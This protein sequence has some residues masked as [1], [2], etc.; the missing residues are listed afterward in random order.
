MKNNRTIAAQNGQNLQWRFLIKITFVLLT[1][2]L[3]SPIFC[4]PMNIEDVLAISRPYG[5]KL[6]PDARYVAW[7]R[8]NQLHIASI[9]NPSHHFKLSTANEILSYQW[10]NPG[11]HLE[12]SFKNQSSIAI[13]AQKKTWETK[14]TPTATLS[15]SASPT[16]NPL[17][18]SPNIIPERAKWSP[19]RRYAFWISQTPQ[20]IWLDI[21][22]LVVYDTRSKTQK[23]FHQTETPGIVA[24]YGYNPRTQEIYYLGENGVGYTLFALSIKTEKIRA[25]TPPGKIWRDLSFSE[26]FKTMAGVFE[27]GNLPPEVYVTAVSQFEPRPITQDHQ[28]YTNRQ[29]GRVEVIHWKAPDGAQVEGL[30][31]HPV[32]QSK[33]PKHPL[34]VWLHGGPASCFSNRFANGTWH[35]PTQV[36]AGLGYTILMP[37]CRGSVGYGP[38]WSKALIGK[39]GQIDAEDIEAGVDAVLA[40]YQWIDSKN[41]ALAGWSYGGYLAA[42]LVNRSNRFKTASIGAGFSDLELLYKTIDIPDWME[43]YLGT[44]LTADILMAHSALQHFK[45]QNTPILI[46]H[47]TKDTRVPISQARRL[48]Q[49]L[50]QLK[51]PHRL[52]EY[53][54]EG[55]IIE[56]SDAKKACMEENIQWFETHLK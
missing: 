3:N 14:D 9:Q 30:L 42:I 26:D 22:Y 2:L 16:P 55:H 35:Y 6:S 10:K 47:G 39:W 27:S 49:H 18:V 20:V 28:H 48:D 29:L 33:K 19:D 46:Q 7:R 52:T 41:V 38:Q 5:I 15:V 31:V 53:P 43:L 24:L 37:N 25:L 51:I 17:I 8:E 50:T 4:R 1:L 21:R 40:R 13:W 23:D 45:N 32:S 56:S 12:V 34:I 36:L 44:P 54:N 11:P